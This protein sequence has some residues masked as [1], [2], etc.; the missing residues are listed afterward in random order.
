M[1]HRNALPSHPAEPLA[2][3]KTIW[4]PAW[5]LAFLTVSCNPVPSSAAQPQE[6]VSVFAPTIPGLPSGYTGLPRELVEASQRQRLLHGVTAAVAEKGYGTTTIGDITARAGVSKRTFYEHFPDRLACFL[7]AHD[8]G[9]QAMLDAVTGASRDALEAGMDSVDQLRAANRAYLAFLVDE[10]PYA[11]MFFLETP[12]AGPEAIARYGD[13]RERFVASLRIWHDHARR[14]HPD[15]PAASKVAYEAAMGT[16]HE[17]A[18]ARIATSRTAELA[19]LDDDVL[20]IQC[21]LLRV[22]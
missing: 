2:E 18:L 20:E 6:R 3:P 17:L 21:A 5:T 9:C 15:W 14:E 11:R 19:A 16:V 22:P 7:A 1:C 8:L 4:F 13:C 12:A 10:E